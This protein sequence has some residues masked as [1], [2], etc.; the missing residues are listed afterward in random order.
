MRTIKFRAWPWGKEK[1]EMEHNVTVGKF[2]VFYVNPGA[3]GNG[4]AENDAASLTQHTTIYPEHVPVMQ[5]TGLLDKNGKEIFEG[6]III[7]PQK[8]TWIVEWINGQYRYWSQYKNNGFKL[9]EKTK[10]EVIGN[11][12]ESPELMK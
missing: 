9:S 12:Y 6:D 5:F 4:L 1:G 3:K 11:I 10:C 8:T 2:G 7:I